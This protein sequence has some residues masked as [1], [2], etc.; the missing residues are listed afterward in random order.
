MLVATALLSIVC[1]IRVAGTFHTCRAG[2]ERSRSNTFLFVY[3]A[4]TSAASVLSA[5]PVDEGDD[6]IMVVAEKLG[7][8]AVYPHR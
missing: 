2:A 5:T 4:T 7:G 3:T 1:R 6:D 8:A